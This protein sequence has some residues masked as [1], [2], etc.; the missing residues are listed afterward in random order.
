M[1]RY[2]P[3]LASEFA[4]WLSNY[5]VT[6]DR[7][8]KL[9]ANKIVYNLENLEDYNMVKKSEDELGIKNDDKIELDLN[10]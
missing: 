9:Y 3:V 1:K 8:E 4:S 5:A 6:E 10:K 7:D 2:Y